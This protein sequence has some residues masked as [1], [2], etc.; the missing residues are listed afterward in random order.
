MLFSCK[1]IQQKLLKRSH[2]QNGAARLLA[3]PWCAPLP[4]SP[5]GRGAWGTVLPKKVS[6]PGSHGGGTGEGEGLSGIL[7]LAISEVPLE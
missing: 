5:Q 1:G 4:P 2:P 7:S 6:S 3:L